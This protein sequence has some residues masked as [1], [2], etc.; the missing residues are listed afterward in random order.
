M[1][2]NYLFIFIFVTSGLKKNIL[3]IRFKL[4]IEKNSNFSDSGIFIYTGDYT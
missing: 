4:Y 2:K 3:K 1:S